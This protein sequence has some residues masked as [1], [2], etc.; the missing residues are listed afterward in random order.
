[1]PF[2]HSRASHSEAMERTFS[3]S[4]SRRTTIRSPRSRDMKDIHKRR[5][6]FGAGTGAGSSTSGV[7]RSQNQKTKVLMLF[8]AALSALLAGC[9]QLTLYLFGGDKVILGGGLLPYWRLLHSSRIFSRHSLLGND[10]AVEIDEETGQLKQSANEEDEIDLVSISRKM[11]HDEIELEEDGRGEEKEL[12]STETCVENE[13]DT[14]SVEKKSRSSGRAGQDEGGSLEEQDDE[15][16]QPVVRRRLAEAPPQPGQSDVY[17]VPRSGGSTTRQ[18]LLDKAWSSEQGV[19]E[20]SSNPAEDILNR[21]ILAEPHGNLDVH[22]A[23]QEQGNLGLPPP[24]IPQPVPTEDDDGEAHLGDDPNLHHTRD[25]RNEPPNTDQEEI[26]PQV[27]RARRNSYNQL[28]SAV[29]QY[30]ASEGE[31]FAFLNDMV[32]IHAD[33]TTD[34]RVD[35]RR[36]MYDE[37]KKLEAARVYGSIHQ[38]AYYFVDLLIGDPEAQRTSVIIDTGSS[39]CGYPCKGCS[40]CGR[41][42]DAAFD[43]S[44]SKSF[45]WIKCNANC[46]CQGDKC[47]YSQGYTEG[48]SISGHWFEDYARLGDTIQHNPPVKVKMGCHMSENKLFYTQ[49]ANG[50]FGLAGN[51]GGNL[52]TKPT[53]LADILRDREH[54]NAKIFTICLA[55]D[56]GRLIAGGYNSSYHEPVDAPIRYVPL[57]A[58]SKF[59][60]VSLS[61]TKVGGTLLPA[62]NYGRTIVDSGTTYSYFPTAVFRS[63]RKQLYSQ[64]QGKCGTR[65]GAECWS[66]PGTTEDNIETKFPVIEM[67]ISGQWF[68]WHPRSYMYRR[69]KGSTLCFTFDDNGSGG[70][71]LGASWMIDRSCIFDLEKRQIGFADARCPHFSAANRPRA[72]QPGDFAKSSVAPVAPAA[73]SS[74]GVKPS[75]PATTAPKPT[76]AAAAAA[77]PSPATAAPATPS[78]ASSKTSATDTTGG[79]TTPEAASSSSTAVEKEKSAWLPSYFAQKDGST[80]AAASNAANGVVT[81]LA[82]ALLTCSCVQMYRAFRKRTS[83]TVTT[84][85]PEDGVPVREWIATDSSGVVTGIPLSQRDPRAVVSGKSNTERLE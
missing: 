65:R 35:A 41:H 54:V 52:R 26:E 67:E 19:A 44:K 60:V 1:M 75:S 68:K 6:E 33:P 34:T 85:N 82:L 40:H 37:A 55:Q 27:D 56:G 78:A 42:I 4:R 80:S 73:S 43:V 47:S 77:Q 69:G 74:S 59:Y 3:S 30:A 15:E 13:D 20:Q 84:Q 32:E 11:I 21:R 5:D 53:I 51:G 23:P 36:L 49:K 7:E 31:N 10:L 28:D 16:F 22:P 64:C 70:T 46:N 71:V 25:L 58:N 48:S 81:L 14:T 76:P 62:A 29:G 50:I 39:L 2:M 18:S 57:G 66:S 38:F 61:K 8:G 24:V 12:L 79:S 9:P 45:H 63:L 17:W 83:Y 72:P